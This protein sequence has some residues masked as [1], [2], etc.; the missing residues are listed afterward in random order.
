MP[1]A[2]FLDG[3]RITLQQ[4]SPGLRLTTEQGDNLLLSH[5]S[6]EETREVVT[7]NY[8]VV[9]EYYRPRAEGYLPADDLRYMVLRI[10][11]HWFYIYQI[12]RGMYVRERNRD[13]A[14][15]TEDFSHPQTWDIIID[16]AKAR[17]PLRY[18]AICLRLL[19]M[20]PD[21]FR[22]YEKNRKGFY[23]NR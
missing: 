17:Y 8:G 14:F 6:E 7:Q 2:F 9:M 16:F 3:I 11:L 13:L 15:R 18:D 21:A 22:N 1:I 12:W 10:V 19:E 20:P 23:E 5:V 4:E